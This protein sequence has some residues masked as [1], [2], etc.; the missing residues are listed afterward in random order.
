MKLY[1]YDALTGDPVIEN[2]LAWRD[3]NDSALYYSACAGLLRSREGLKDHIAAA[4]LDVELP[5]PAGEINEYFAHDMGEIFSGLLD[6]DW[7]GLCR[8]RG[9]LPFPGSSGNVS[10]RA[11]DYNDTL[12][13]LAGAGSPAMLSAEL[14]AFF[15]RYSCAGEAKYDAFKWTDTGIG[16]ISRTDPVT[17]DDLGA[18]GS[19]KDILITNAEAFIH[20]RPAHDMLLVG[21]AGTGKSSCVKAVFNMFRPEGLKLVELFKE[22]IAG[23]PALMDEVGRRRQKHLIFIDD[24]SFDGSEADYKELKVTLDGQ[25][26]QRPENMLIF[27]TSNRIHLIKETW[28]D[29]EVDVDIHENETLS[30]KMSLAERFGLRLVFYPL[31][32]AEYYEIIGLLLGKGGVD[33]DEKI[34]RAAS[35]WAI[36]AGGMSGR[37]AKQFVTSYLS[38]VFSRTIRK[39]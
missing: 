24:L 11:S 16:G 12:A 38:E 36:T 22:D 4:L 31:S 34:A 27:A 35:E 7:N 23:L 21:A 1:L 9:L 8:E 14:T 19:K 33:F 17:F 10:A 13:R 5:C 3:S 15:E 37:V 25:I 28:K 20:G 26:G 30:E 29:R 6:F 39:I 2:L 32:Q 18:L